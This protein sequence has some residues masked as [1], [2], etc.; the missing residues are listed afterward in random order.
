MQQELASLCQIKLRKSVHK[1]P[2]ALVVSDRDNYCG[3][4]HKLG[5]SKLVHQ[6]NLQ[7]RIDCKH[8]TWHTIS[9]SS[10]HL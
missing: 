7:H 8:T 5:S 6:P 10:T 2:P 1:N 4:T 9:S 3:I